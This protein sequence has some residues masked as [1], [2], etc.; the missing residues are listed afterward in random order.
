MKNNGVSTAEFKKSEKMFINNSKEQ[1]EKKNLGNTYF[2]EEV[3]PYCR[4]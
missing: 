4:V 1:K 3:T 2:L